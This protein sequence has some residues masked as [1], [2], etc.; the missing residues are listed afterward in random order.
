MSDLV[1]EVNDDALHIAIRQDLNQLGLVAHMNDSI[2]NENSVSGVY[3]HHTADNIAYE[4]RSINGENTYTV[5][6]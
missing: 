3:C 4:D 1:Q 2:A 6:L 5:S